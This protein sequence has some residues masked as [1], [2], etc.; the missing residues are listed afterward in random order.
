MA[1]TD[2]LWMT[3]VTFLPTLFAV[4]LL[5]FPRGTDE[6][7]RWWTL[8]GTALTLGASLGMFFEFRQHMGERQGVST[9]PEARAQSALSTRAR[10][11]EF[12]PPGTV[13]RSD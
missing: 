13:A 5:F 3:A 7:M 11:L 8:F 4:G 1:E 12:A 10:D 2:L 6:G 9:T